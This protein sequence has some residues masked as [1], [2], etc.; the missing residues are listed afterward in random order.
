L[1]RLEH[2]NEHVPIAVFGKNDG[3]KVLT[4]HGSKGLEFEFVWIA[5]SS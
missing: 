3:V 5:L 1:E 4:L 2:Y